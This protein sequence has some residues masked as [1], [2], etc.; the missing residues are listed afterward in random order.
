MPSTPAALQQIPRR[1]WWDWAVLLGTSTNPTAWGGGRLAL[2]AEPQPGKLGAGWDQR[3]HAQ[4]GQGIRTTS[5]PAPRPQQW[6][7]GEP[8]RL[9]ELVPALKNGRQSGSA[10]AGSSRP[11]CF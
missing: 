2:V 11:H 5:L 6:G 9:G 4:V 10:V 1:H 3:Q 7:Q 8:W